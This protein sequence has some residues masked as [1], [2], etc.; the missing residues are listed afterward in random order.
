[1]CCFI[2][3]IAPTDDADGVRAVMARHDRAA[4]VLDN[5][6]VRTVLLPGERQYLT[7]RGHCDCGTVLGRWVAPEEIEAARAK[8][9]A[10]MQRKGWSAAKIA[11]AMEGHDKTKAKRSRGDDTDTLEFWDVVLSDL[12]D[13]LRL[14]Y[15]GLLVRQYSGAIESAVFD[16]SRTEL[17]KQIDR[18]DALHAMADD[19]VTIFPLT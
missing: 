16:A 17:P 15:V 8:E 4:A 14:P 7:T 11:R 1:M 5:R 9:V 13:T 6:S 19:E 2:T 12:G 18:R 3:L 10:R